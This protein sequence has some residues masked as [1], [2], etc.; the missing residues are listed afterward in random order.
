MSRSGDRQHKALLYAC[1][2]AEKNGREKC[3]AANIIIVYHSFFLRDRLT[4][5]ASAESSD[6]V[7]YKVLC[8]CI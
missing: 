5:L 3:S 2:C 6:S 1:I 8:A 4:N 7:Y